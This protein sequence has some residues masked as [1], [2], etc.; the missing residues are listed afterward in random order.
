MAIIA[1]NIYIIFQRAIHLDEKVL[2]L[3]VF[4]FFVF[5]RQ[6]ICMASLR[7]PLGFC[8]LNLQDCVRDKISVA[9][10]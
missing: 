7:Y 5:F 9:I 10:L 8:F 1:G 3:C 2:N 4:R 6:N